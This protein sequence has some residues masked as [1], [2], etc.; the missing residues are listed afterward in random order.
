MK[1]VLLA[2][3]LCLPLMSFAQ[4]AAVA[5]KD[6]LT[7]GDAAAGAAKAATCAACHG[8]TGNS[9]NPEWPKLAGQ[10]SAY[11]VTQLKNFKSGARKQA[12]MMGMAGSLSDQDM[13]DVAA[14]FASQ[15]MEPGV[16]S[17]DA[18]A[19]AEKLYRA[20]DAARGLPAC[21]ACHGPTGAGNAAA[22]YPRLGGQHAKYVATQLT[23]FKSGERSI[24]ANGQMMAAVAAK[25]TDTEIAALSSYV[26]G[27]Q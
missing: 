5:K 16:A 18:V 11:L 22:A 8:P 15:K 23:S 4:E 10:S 7:G 19:V 12:V 24:G 14:H 9:S 17:K 25:L 2:C 13:K 6:A 21:A 3:A 27:L 1:R 26:N 20:G